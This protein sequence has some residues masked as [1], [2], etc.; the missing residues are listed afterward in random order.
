M[1]ARRIIHIFWPFPLG[2]RHISDIYSFTWKHQQEHRIPICF[3]HKDCE[4]H[5]RS[6]CTVAVCSVLNQAMDNESS[7]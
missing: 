7:G 5:L 3:Y 4:N 6:Q 2:L 1:K